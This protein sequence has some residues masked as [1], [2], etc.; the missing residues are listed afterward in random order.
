MSRSVTFYCVQSFAWRG[1]RLVP[2]D[3]R[4]LG[5]AAEAGRVG[6]ACAERASGVVVFAVEGDAGAD[7]WEERRVLASYGVVPDDMPG[8]GG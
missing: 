3:V 6:R 4:R 5:D 1:G 7:V 2:G 8:E